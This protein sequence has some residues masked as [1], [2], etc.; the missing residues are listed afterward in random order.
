ML[1]TQT[2]LAKSNDLFQL[3]QAKSIIVQLLCGLI[4]A[5]MNVCRFAS[6]TQSFTPPRRHRG[7]RRSRLKSRAWASISQAQAAHVDELAD[8]TIAMFGIEEPTPGFEELV[9]RFVQQPVEGVVV[10]ESPWSHVIARDRRDRKCGS[11][12]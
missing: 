10:W 1:T 7:R 4:A 11:R 3:V 2:N 8:H 6:L 9:L 12:F 5:A